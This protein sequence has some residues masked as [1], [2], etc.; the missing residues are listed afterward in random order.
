[1]RRVFRNILLGL[2]LL[3]LLT[4]LA[5]LLTW[6]YLIKDLSHDPS[7]WV[8][9]EI[10]QRESPLLRLVT[11]VH[12]GAIVV[13]GAIVALGA[14]FSLIGWGRRRWMVPN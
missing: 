1:M 8:R 2:C 3:V 4:W 6:E 11:I 10:Q 5:Q 14:I 13:L 7:H 12:L 9:G